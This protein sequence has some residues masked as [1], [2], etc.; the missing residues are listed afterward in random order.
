M[1]P[2]R[3]GRLTRLTTLAMVALAAPWLTPERA[4]AYGLMVP[5]GPSGDAPAATPPQNREAVVVVLREGT[6]TVL[7]FQN[8]Y[9]G[10]ARDFA[11]IVPV[12]VVLDPSDVRTLHASVLELVEHAAAPRMVELW[13]QDPCA[14]TPGAGS[15]TEATLS[16]ATSTQGFAAGAPR[17]EPANVRVESEFQVGEY[18]MVV[19][20]AS[21][22]EQLETWL[23]DQGYILPEG[24][25]DALRPYLEAGMKFLVA[26]VDVA[27]L[28]ALSPAHAASLG[29][30]RVLLS[31]IRLHYDSERFALPVR[32]GLPN[33]PGEQ[34]LTVHVLSPEG[35]FTPANY[36][37]RFL[38]TNQRVDD[39]ALSLAAVYESLFARLSRGAPRTLFTEYAA[40]VTPES[41]EASCLGCARAGVPAAALNTLGAAELPGHMPWASEPG[42]ARLAQFVLTRIRYRYTPSGLPDDLL[43]EHGSPVAAGFEHAPSARA[44]VRPGRAT[45]NAYGVRFLREHRAA[46]A[47]R[48]RSPRPGEWSGEP[49]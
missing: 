19:L 3:R 17:P 40:L 39:A 23:R 35:R 13:Q 2:K 16:S 43:F 48:C 31:P 33:S 24:A 9:L 32:L 37:S 46:D 22:S 7:T 21:D 44:V 26:K 25:S 38:P 4:A 1:V 11:L 45:Q 29:A 41:S 47:Q 28:A 10:P 8:D 18:D 6:R 36:R 42:Q 34:D 15:D 14:T 12:P 30:G 20:G 27:R 49:R 5:R